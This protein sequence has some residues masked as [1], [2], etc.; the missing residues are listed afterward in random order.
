MRDK[1]KEIKISKG[2]V[3]DYIGMT[4]DYIVPVQVSI[5]MIN[6]ER[7]IL[8]EC[9]VWSL[10]ATPAAS[11]LFDTRDAP[12]AS[13]EEVQFFRTFVAK[14]LYIA[15]RVRPEGIVAVAFLTTRVHEV[16]EGDMGK[17]KRVLGY[18]R[19]T[20]NRGRHPA[21]CGGHHDY[22]R[23]YRRILWGAPSQRKVAH[24]LRQ[25]A[26]RGRGVIRSLLQA[27][28]CDE[29]QHQGIVGWPLR[30]N[31]SGYLPQEFCGEA[32]LLRWFCD[33]FPRQPQLHGINEARWAGS[34][35]SRHI[36][37][38]H[39]WV[40]ERLANGEVTTE[41]VNINLMHANALNK[42]VQGAQFE[43]ERSGLIN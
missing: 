19:A 3:V 9:G 6:F 1:Y 25:S 28:D 36:N 12:K 33:Y 8:S 27:K 42:P 7:S 13:H 26:R 32:R 24:R 11:A 14:L 16:D 18:L 21:A 17:V 29:V 2:K 4:F 38:R 5:T 20:S 43:R 35:R 37:I 34:E 30:L 23:I 15:K 41:H 31:G 10:R 22:P 39:F 40:A